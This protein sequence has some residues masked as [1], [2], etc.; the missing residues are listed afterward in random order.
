MSSSF[1]YVSLSTTVLD[2]HSCK[3]KLQSTAIPSL[4]ESDGIPLTRK[5]PWA[6][7]LDTQ[8]WQ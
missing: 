3:V 6:E 4:S 8:S 2:H 5:T 1:F 7:Q